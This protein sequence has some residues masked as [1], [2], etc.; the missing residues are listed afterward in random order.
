M[1]SAEAENQL[2]IWNAFKAQLMAQGLDEDDQCLLDTLEGATSLHEVLISMIGAAVDAEAMAEVQQKHISD[3][4]ERKARY[5]RRAER[6]R[7]FALQVMESAGLKRIESPRF[8]FGTSS[9]PQ[10]VVI[11]NPESLP[12]EYLRQKAP[13]P[14]LTAIGKALKAGEEIPGAILGN[15]GTTLQ[16]RTR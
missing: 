4:R 2:R 14:D 9:T 8:T 13:E 6:L 3:L 12:K 5:E 16:I 10:K 11:T 1:N 7:S 15:G